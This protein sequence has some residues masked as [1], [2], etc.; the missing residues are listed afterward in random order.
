MKKISFV[1]FMLCFTIVEA[2][3]QEQISIS[4]FQGQKITG[5]EAHGIFNITAKQGTTTGVTVNIPARLEKQLVLKLDSDGKLQ[6][7]IEGKITSK[8]RKNN[9]DD[10]FTAEVTVTTLNNVEL[11]GVC[12]LETIGDF[13]T[14][15]LKVDL[16]GASKMLINGDFLTKEKLEI[17]L[18][19]AS[20]LKG[21]ITSPESSFDISG[22]SNLT[23]KGN[24]I[25]CKI[26]VSGASKAALDDFPINE[27][28]AEVSGAARAQFQVKEKISLH[29]SGA[30]KAT[31]SGDP[32]ILS[33]HSSGASNINKIS[34]Q[35]SETRKEY[36]K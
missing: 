36:E 22:A 8:N 28:K 15:K 13:T 1:I 19:G 20:H 9:D 24:T 25:H 2:F 33:L 35:S 4:R 3:S 23:L 12:K 21:R 18:S 29:T 30:S 31:Y 32:I 17:E 5:I 6:I 34:S 14:N 11:T 7:Y 26:E 27:L 10:H 16:S